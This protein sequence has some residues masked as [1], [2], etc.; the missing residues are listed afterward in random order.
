MK[1]RR[2][3]NLMKSILFTMLL[4]TFSLSAFAQNI[5]VKG[6]ITDANDVSLIGVTVQ[7]QG[8]TAGTVTDFDGNYVLN[9]VPADG[10]LEVSYVGMQSQTVNVNGQTTINVVL[11]ED[12][13]LLDELVVVGYGTM[14]KSDVTGSITVT[15]GEDMIKAQSFNALDNLRGKAAG[16][17][18]FSNSG[19]PGGPTRVMIRGI[20]TIN[21]SSNPLYV[22]DGVVMEDFQIGR[23]HV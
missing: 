21:S 14:R 13:E 22:V 4:C 3:L 8:T 10:V 17:N 18:I 9:N 6:T 1:R 15:K 2:S 5:T 12:S 7:V 19:Q 20:G 23:A 11:R 16:V